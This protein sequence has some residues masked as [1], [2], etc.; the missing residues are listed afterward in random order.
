MNKSHARGGG[1]GGLRNYIKA[2]CI[3]YSLDLLL[4]HCPYR[5]MMLFSEPEVSGQVETS[6]CITSQLP[7]KFNLAYL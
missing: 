3:S 6:N 1:G 4:K 5:M 7:G 2:I